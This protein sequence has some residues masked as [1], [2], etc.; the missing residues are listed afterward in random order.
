MLAFREGTFEQVDLVAAAK[1]A[2]PSNSLGSGECSFVA[3]MYWCGCDRHISGHVFQS[4]ADFGAR[5]MM[6]LATAGLPVNH[7]GSYQVVVLTPT[8][9]CE[10][11][12]VRTKQSPKKSST[13]HMASDQTVQ[14]YI[15]NVVAVVHE[16]VFDIPEEHDMQL[17]VAPRA[18]GRQE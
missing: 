5:V 3:P 12:A 15:T 18:E 4:F 2:H 16:E 1:N 6:N 13:H 10:V 8:Y 11:F 14:M 7:D 17:V 9:T